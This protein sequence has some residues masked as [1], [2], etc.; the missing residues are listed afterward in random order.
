MSYSKEYL[1][2]VLIQLNKE[3]GK[4]PTRSMLNS[5]KGL[6]SDMAYRKHFGSWGKALKEAGFEPTKPFP[7]RKAIENSVNARKGKKGG[8]NKGGK[9]INEYGYI[10]VWKPEHP[11]ADSKGYVKE[12]RL[13]MSDYLGR[14]LFPWEDVHHKNGI[15]TDNR[16][17]NLEVLSKGDHSAL[18]ERIQPEKH[19]RKESVVCIY[20]GCTTLTSSKYSLCTKHYR[21]QWGRMKKGLIKEITEIKEIS[22]TH[23]EETKE[24]LSEIAKKQLRKNGRFAKSQE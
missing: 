20:P 19:L 21:L 16:I 23:S 6:P 1:I 15:K 22:R 9:R 8:N 4:V 13:V 14:P 17:E 10:E 12:H 2:N 11:N 18:H 5:K 7:S 24:L 3:T